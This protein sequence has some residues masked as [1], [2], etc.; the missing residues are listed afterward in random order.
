MALSV[1]G[2]RQAFFCGQVSLGARGFLYRSGLLA[3]P[4]LVIATSAVANWSEWSLAH[5]WRV[6]GAVPGL[7]FVCNLINSITRILDTDEPMAGAFIN[8]AA[9]QATG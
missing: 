3:N 9:G 4:W 7:G 2:V 1:V 6:S 8:S 5:A